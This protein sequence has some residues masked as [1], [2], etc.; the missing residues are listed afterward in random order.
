MSTSEL[1]ETV[2]RQLRQSQAHAGLSS[3]LEHF[4]TE[5]AGRQVEGHGHTAWQQLE[6]MRLAAEDLIAYCQDPDYEA[7]EWPAGY[8]PETPEPPSSESWSASGRCLLDAT[9]Q[10]AQM[11]EDPDLDLYAK[12]PA[13]KKETHHTLRAALILLDHNGYHAAQLIALRQA[14]NAWPP[15]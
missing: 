12:V 8:W 7:R 14:L 9:E 11:V 3:A 10:M 15:D 5:H 1:R 2:A 13:A 4:P 6:H